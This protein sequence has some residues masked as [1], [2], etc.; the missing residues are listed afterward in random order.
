MRDNNATGQILIRLPAEKRRFQ[1]KN[2]PQDWQR[3]LTNYYWL[4]SRASSIGR[5]LIVPEMALNKMSR[6]L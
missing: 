2:K 4:I 3:V 5:H 6:F 1:G